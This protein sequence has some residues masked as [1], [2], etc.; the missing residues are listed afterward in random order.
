MTEYKI[1][2]I[3]HS[4]HIASKEQTHLFTEIFDDCC[5]NHMKHTNKL[6]WQNQWFFNVQAY[7][8]KIVA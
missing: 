5:K 4:K 7:I 2:I 3:P 8:V 6:C 1:Y